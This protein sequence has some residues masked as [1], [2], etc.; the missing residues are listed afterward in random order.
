MLK[1]WRRLL[2]IRYHRTLMKLMGITWL[3]SLVYW[4][5]VSVLQGHIRELLLGRLKWRILLSIVMWGDRVVWFGI[6]VEGMMECL[7]RAANL[8]RSSLNK[9]WD[10][11]WLHSL[12]RLWRFLKRNIG[13][14]SLFRAKIYLGS[15]RLGY[16]GDAFWR[17]LLRSLR[18]RSLIFFSQ[19]SEDVVVPVLFVV[20]V[21]MLQRNPK[22]L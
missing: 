6:Y 18:G 13:F 4:V 9:L 17:I 21:G 5:N 2:P 3:R 8:L 11:L 12:R 1:T 16:L 14:L 15:F 22:L 20:W 7:T 19:G 10:I